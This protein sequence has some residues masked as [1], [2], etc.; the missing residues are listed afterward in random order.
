MPGR[1]CPKSRVIPRGT[2]RVNAR[3]EG[4]C[5]TTGNGS[6]EG[7]LFG[8]QLLVSGSQPGN[9]PGPI[10]SFANSNATY[11]SATFQWRPVADASAY[12]LALFLVAPDADN[13]VMNI[14]LTKNTKVSATRLVPNRNYY[15]FLWAFNASGGSMSN[16]VYFTTLK[17]P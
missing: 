14:Y 4:Y 7:S 10:T 11:D 6:L 15:A 1:S 8:T 12:E 2:Q 9:K 13:G 5:N 17:K 16:E 3:G